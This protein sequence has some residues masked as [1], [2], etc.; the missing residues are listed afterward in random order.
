MDT[1]TDWTTLPLREFR[2]EPALRTAAHRVESAGAPAIDV[3][4]HLGLRRGAGGGQ[5]GAWAVRDVG[6]LL[7]LMDECNVEAIVNLD[8]NWGET[9]EANLNRYDRAHPGRFATFCRL[10]WR[11]CTRPG[12]PGRLAE[13]LR[14]SASQGAAGLKVWKDVGLHVRDESGNLVLCDDARLTPVWEAAAELRLPVLI[15]TADP[16]AFFE[17]LS[18]RNERLEELLEH[19]DWRFADA[20]FPRM[21]TLLEALERV[22]Q[23]NPDVT[24][25]GA[26][27]GCFAEDLGWVG[28]MFDRYRNFYADVAARIAELGRQ[29]R[30]T[31]QLLHRHPT[32]VM[33]GTD[34]SPPTKAAYAIYF[35]FFETADEHFPYSTEKPP[36]SGRWAISGVDLDG[37]GLANLYAENARRVIPALRAS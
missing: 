11:E 36:G 27:V 25:I 9:L 17:P 15:H 30:A 7:Q 20:K 31:R 21:D 22:V 14:K 33:L 13:S 8:G 16:L 5:D 28:R 10:D 2:P 6:A 26:H 4:N 18:E 19:P 37:I 23:R 3:H 12:W 24:F 34:V 1:E 29:P 35:R 32:R